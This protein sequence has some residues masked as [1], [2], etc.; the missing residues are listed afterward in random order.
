MPLSLSSHG[1][2]AREER[3]TMGPLESSEESKLSVELC[4]RRFAAAIG[5][6]EFEEHLSV[7]EEC[8]NTEFNDPQDAIDLIQGIVTAAIQE[9]ERAGKNLEKMREDLMKMQGVLQ[10]HDERPFNASVQQW[11]TQIATTLCVTAS[12]E[13][14][15]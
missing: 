6:D 7:L 4:I 13:E 5:T 11:V 1:T 14:R 15:H 8:F 2:D 10:S 12:Q 9:L 3:A